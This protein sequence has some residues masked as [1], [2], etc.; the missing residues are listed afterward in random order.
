MSI[1]SFFKRYLTEITNAEFKNRYNLGPVIG[2]GA[3]ADVHSAIQVETGRS[4]AVKKLT[5]S[6]VFSDYAEW[7]CS[8]ERVQAEIAIHS[9]LRH[10]NIA[11]FH[12]ALMDEKNIYVVMELVEGDALANHMEDA[13][14]GLSIQSVLSFVKQ[15]LNVLLYLHSRGVAHGDFHRM[16]IMMDGDELKV[17]DF[18]KGTAA[19]MEQ[20]VERFSGGSSAGASTSSSRSIRRDFA[21]DI[22]MCVRGLEEML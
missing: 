21:T 17:I 2:S 5:K 14:S 16:N 1:P 10:Q 13:E 20:L 4:V 22:K 18:G 11:K 3:Q 7:A 6:E 9:S 8:P 19:N 15:Q 12:E